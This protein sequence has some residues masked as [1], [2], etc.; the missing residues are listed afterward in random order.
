MGYVQT[1]DTD[2]YITNGFM[3]EVGVGLVVEGENLSFHKALMT[4][5]FLSVLT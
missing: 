1:I 5:V 2:T 3:V 4:F